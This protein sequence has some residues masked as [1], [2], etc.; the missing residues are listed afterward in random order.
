MCMLLRVASE[1]YLTESLGAS[2]RQHW[3]ELWVARDAGWSEVHPPEVHWHKM[4]TMTTILEWTEN[5]DV[6]GPDKV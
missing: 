5:I 4:A 1:A 6:H 3:I 2:G